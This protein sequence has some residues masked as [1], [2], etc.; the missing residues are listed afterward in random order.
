MLKQ[1]NITPQDREQFRNE[2]REQFQQL[3]M[4]KAQEAKPAQPTQD[5]PVQEAAPRK[6]GAI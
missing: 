4:Q 6:V 2:G 3:Q 1:L 5:A